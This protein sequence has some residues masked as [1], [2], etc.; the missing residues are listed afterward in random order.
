MTLSMIVKTVVA[1]SYDFW[2]PHDPD[3]ILDMISPNSV[4]SLRLHVYQ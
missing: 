4:G 2:N 1:Q 3:H